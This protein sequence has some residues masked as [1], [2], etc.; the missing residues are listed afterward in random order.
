M[1]H[2]RWVRLAAALALCFGLLACK[3]L[4]YSNLTEAE[5][6]EIVAVLGAS[7]L[8]LEKQQGE[9]GRWRVEVAKPDFA[10]AVTLMKENGLPRSKFT[11]IG[12]VFKKEGLVSTPTEER[13]RFIY[14]MSQELAA[15]LSQID[16]VVVARV[17]PVL[18]ANDPL[19]EKVV[20]ASASVF[21]K[22]RPN[23]NLKM[24]APAIK[25][26]VMSSIEGLTYDNIALSFFVVDSADELDMSRARTDAAAASGYDRV[27]NLLVTVGAGCVFLAAAA[28]LMRRRPAGKVAKPGFG[29]GTLGEWQR[30]LRSWLGKASR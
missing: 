7:A 5:A 6:N 17:H 30:Q 26:L 16:G 9:D 18:P 13:I 25:E 12:E 19:V 29:A 21:I 22:H 23:A 10:R 11:S 27:F 1:N 2:L 24:L 4:L 8:D 15:T 3:Q 20:P 14:A 28:L